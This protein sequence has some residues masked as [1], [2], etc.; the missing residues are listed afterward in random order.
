MNFKNYGVIFILEVIFMVCALWIM[1]TRDKK[2]LNK[3]GAL[4]DSPG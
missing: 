4:D 1:E 3:E 2:A